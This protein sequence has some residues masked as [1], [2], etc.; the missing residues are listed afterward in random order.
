MKKIAILTITEGG[1]RLAESLAATLTGSVVYHCRGGL[2]ETVRSVWQQGQALIFIMACGIVVR[3]VA[4]LL[5]SKRSDP[6]VVVMDEK[7]CF[8]VSLLA[9]HLGGANS[10]ATKVAGIVGGQ[11]VITTASDVLG[12]TALDLWS[13]QLELTPE[14]PTRFPEPMGILVN[15]GSVTLHS[16]YPLPEVPADIELVDSPAEADMVI[17]CRVGLT[18]SAFL[19]W[20]KSLVVGIGCNRG[21]SAATIETALTEVFRA[22]CLSVQAIRQLAT[23]D[24]KADEQGLLDFASHRGYTIT[25][26]HHD[27]LNKIDNVSA[28]EV[29][30]RATGT[31]S[32]AEAAAILGAGNGN[33]LVRKVKCKDV[34]IAVAEVSSPWSVPAPAPPTW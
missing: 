1:R 5:T 19:L 25:F 16:D 29:V 21:V 2:A 31:K 10:L 23:I 26:F 27:Q 32:V 34:T 11:A 18:T 13:Q 6:A 30:F 17:T 15:N 33:L 24:I 3:T 14:N 8:V 28:S 22:N 9:G 20:P 4:P 12:R 7:G